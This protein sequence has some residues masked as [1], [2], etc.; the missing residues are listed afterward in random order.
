PEIIE[1]PQPFEQ[2]FAYG[3]ELF[4]LKHP[5]TQA[6][7]QFLAALELSKRRRTLSEEQLGRLQ[8]ALDDLFAYEYYEDEKDYQYDSA[9]RFIDLHNIFSLAREVQLFDIGKIEDLAPTGEEL[10]PGTIDKRPSNLETRLQERRWM[11]SIRTF[12]QPLTCKPP[13]QLH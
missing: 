6:L 5:T 9:N 2:S 7:L 8:D 13:D 1:F 4:N 10:V 11:R 12:G 3:W